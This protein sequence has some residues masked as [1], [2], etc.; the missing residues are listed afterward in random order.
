MTLSKPSLTRT[1]RKRKIDARSPPDFCA[2]CLDSLD[3]GKEVQSFKCGHEFHEDC[4]RNLSTCPLCRAPLVKGFFHELE[5]LSAQRPLSQRPLRCTLKHGERATLK[6][7]T[8]YVLREGLTSGPLDEMS[9]DRMLEISAED[10]VS[11][12]EIGWFDFRLERQD[13]ATELR[14]LFPPDQ[15]PNFFD[16][17]TGPESLFL[18]LLNVAAAMS[19]GVS[20]II[21]NGFIIPKSRVTSIEQ[22][23][24]GQVM[25]THYSHNPL[26]RNAGNVGAFAVLKEGYK[27]FG[28]TKFKV[29]NSHRTW[30]EPTTWLQ[31]LRL[32][33]LRQY[34]RMFYI[35]TTTLEMSAS[36]ATHGDANDASDAS[37]ALHGDA[38]DASNATHGDT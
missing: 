15:I 5:A 21:E 36:D 31:R 4:I 25:H 34:P 29:Q 35:R 9:N 20:T 3:N 16:G 13:F 22:F 38:N 18:R 12:H 8:V 19:G 28:R 33:S 23:A 17:Y 1:S 11:T 37:D 32:R 7:F 30:T 27:V 6:S 2:I 26:P 14:E 10:I 24:S